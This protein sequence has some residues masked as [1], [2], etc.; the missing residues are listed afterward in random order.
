[1][2]GKFLFKV[3]NMDSQAIADL[4]KLIIPSAI[5]LLGVFFTVN[6]TLKNYYR[7]KWWSRKEENYAN[8]ISLN[9]TIL[10]D[11]YKFN[12]ASHQSEDF[13]TLE[14]MRVKF[15]YQLTA[16]EE[17]YIKSTAFLSEDARNELMIKIYQLKALVS[18]F[19]MN[20]KRIET[21]ELSD[22]RARNI[23][24]SMFGRNWEDENKDF[25]KI[26]CSHMN[27]DLELIGYIK[28][29]NNYLSNFKRG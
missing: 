4:L 1:M 22:V 2:I 25:Q 20:I 7:Q 10:I 26:L 11:A 17:G 18:V 21:G 6:V 14:K 28:R 12:M 5:A 29:I 19:R 15:H 16:V 23:S 27:R 8:L 13:E 3:M 9:S 24:V